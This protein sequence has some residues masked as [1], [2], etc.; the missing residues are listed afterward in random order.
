MK[1]WRL[2]FSLFKCLNHRMSLFS[3][4]LKYC[5]RLYGIFSN[6]YFH[7]ERNPIKYFSSYL[8]RLSQYVVHMQLDLDD[9]ACKTKCYSSAECSDYKKK[10]SFAFKIL[11][12][13]CLVKYVCQ[14]KYW[15]STVT[16][17]CCYFS[18]KP[19]CVEF[20]TFLTCHPAVVIS[21]ITLWTLFSTTLKLETLY[22]WKCSPIY[23]LKI[24]V[25]PLASIY[26]SPRLLWVTF[27]P[28][29]HGLLFSC[30]WWAP[31]VYHDFLYM[32]VCVFSELKKACNVTFAL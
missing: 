31:A 1:D 24:N 16:Q 2:L 3:S 12:S 22:R 8:S 15:E 5:I 4:R 9:M 17:Y 6:T 20:W 29:R 32:M 28:F 14:H 19:L 18:L 10:Y 30:E 11:F 26:L 23:D 27:R 25:L 7:I 21:K 13:Q